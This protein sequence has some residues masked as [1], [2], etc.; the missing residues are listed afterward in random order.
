MEQI[1]LY[2]KDNNEAI[3]V[4]SIRHDEDTIYM[5]SGKLGGEEIESTELVKFG[6][7]GRTR[8]Q[9]IEMRIHS[10]IRKKIDSGYVYNLHD[11]QENIRTN[12]LGYQKAAKCSRWDE[13][14]KNVP[15]DETYIQPKLNGHH[16]SIIN[17]G[18]KLIAYSNGGKLI[19]T[20]DHILTGMKLEIGQAIEGELYVHGVKLQTISSWVRK[21]QPNTLRLQFYCYDLVSDKCYSERY[22]ILNK[23]DYGKAACFLEISFVKGR[24]DIIPI[25]KQYIKRGYEGAVVRLKGFAYKAGGRSKGMIKVK[26]MHFG[27]ALMV[28]DEFLVTDIIPSKDG[29]ARLVCETEWGGEFK[30]SCHGTMDYKMK[31]MKNKNFYIGKHVRVEFAEWTADKIPFHGVAKGWRDKENE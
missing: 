29:W 11:A 3:R 6:L 15:Y 17:D 13:E 5:T 8:Q 28:D 7:A 14:E 9:Q 19:T 30:V 16:C 12:A 25:I 27:D 18:G 10:R 26:T 21:L 22:K 1:I 2:S 20:I 4:W 23:I 31:V 24:F